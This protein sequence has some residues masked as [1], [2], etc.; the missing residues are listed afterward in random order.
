MESCWEYDCH[1][2]P[3]FVSILQ[4][5]MAQIPT[6]HIL[7]SSS[8]VNAIFDPCPETVIFHQLFSAAVLTYLHTIMSAP[9]D[10]VPDPVALKQTKIPKYLLFFS[11]NTHFLSLLSQIYQE[12]TVGIGSYGTVSF[13]PGN[14]LFSV[15]SNLTKLRLSCVWFF[16]NCTWAW[17]F[18]I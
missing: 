4:A 6:P 15:S 5:Y 13:H 1:D 8:L 14:G 12:H 17:L 7:A 18:T 11:L 9:V 2:R 10:S 3:S 16:L